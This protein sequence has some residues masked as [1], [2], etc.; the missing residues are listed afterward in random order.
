M[1]FNDIVMIRVVEED[2]E[3]LKLLGDIKATVTVFGSNGHQGPRG[4][5]TL[6]LQRSMLPSEATNKARLRPPIMTCTER[7]SSRM[8]PPTD[9][10]GP[11]HPCRPTIP[12]DQHPRN[13]QTAH[14][15]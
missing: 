3:R 13:V 9:V 11:T 6:R 1:K 7:C 12:G 15:E 4:S 2:F 10:V 8:S 5:P 14:R